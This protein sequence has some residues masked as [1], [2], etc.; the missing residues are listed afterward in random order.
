MMLRN[1]RKMLGTT[2]VVL[3]MVVPILTVSAVRVQAANGASDC[4]PPGPAAIATLEP[5][6]L[7]VESSSDG[8]STDPFDTGIRKGDRIDEFKWLVNDDDSTGDPSLTPENVANCLPGRAAVDAATAAANAALAIY[9]TAGTGSLEDCSWPSVHASSGHSDVIA[10]G[11]QGDTD[12][13]N[14]LPDGKYL[15]SVTAAGYKIDGIH[16]AI[17]GGEVASLNEE[18]GKPFIVRMN[19]LPKKTLTIR[20]HVFNDNASTN[21]EWDGQTETLITCDLATPEQLAANCGGVA[22]PL[23]VA[24]PSTDMSGFTVSLADVLDTTTTDVFGNPLCTQYESDANGI[25]LND[26]GSPNPVVFPDG[27]M[28]GGPLAGTESTC[29]SDHYGDIVIPNMG[30]NRYAVT[31]IPPDPR[32]HSNDVWMRSTTL[33]G[34]HDWDSWNI[35]GGNGYDTELIVGGERTPPVIAG[36]VK[37]T[38]NDKAFE[39]AMHGPGT[40]AEADYYDASDGFTDG[41]YQQ[42]PRHAQRPHRHRSRLHRF[43]RCAATCRRQ[44]RQRSYGYGEGHRGRHHRHQLCRYL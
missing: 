1:W 3:G 11:D 26:D 44:H 36:F 32:T 42:Q 35:E 27:G 8:P 16:F 29:I 39:A 20:V 4:D 22:D 12:S 5:S 13:L 30:P 34:G 14:N 43:R 28:T 17:V 6:S 9:E 31:V 10:S 33:E 38:H 21:G 2:A 19:P 24:D 37:L 18:P 23:V 41:D 40:A 7:C 15:I 25:I